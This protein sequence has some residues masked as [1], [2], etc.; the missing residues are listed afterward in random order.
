MDT[1]ATPVNIPADEPNMAEDESLQKGHFGV[2][3]KYFIEAAGLLTIWSLLVINEGAIRFANLT[4][5]SDLTGGRPAKA[6][7]FVAA[8]MEITFGLIGLAIGASAL[9]L[10]WFNANAVYGA[11]GLQTIMGIYVFLMYV[12]L[13]PIYKSIDQGKIGVM[14]VHV[15]LSLSENRALI[16]M[17]L[18]T[19]FN[20]CLALQG[21]QFV[22]FARLAVGGTGKNVLMQKTGNFMRA[23][24][25]NANLALSG[26]WT[27]VT[28]AVINAQVGDGKLEGPFVSPPNV[29]RLPGLTI[30]TGLLVMLWGFAGIGFAAG[31]MKA[32]A[33]Y[34]YGSFI[35]Y[36]FSYLNYT[37]VQFGLIDA[38]ASFAGPISMHGGLV[39]MVTMLGPYF[40]HQANK[41]IHGE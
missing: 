29:G 25:W 24:F 18:L 6:A 10:K 7:L 11:M 31:K 32:P 4:P 35:V 41:E 15:G 27:I 1:E 2:N 5:L 13:V 3:S 30:F 23:I 26:L 9:V 12:F 14:P 17:G 28:G 39:F 40:V 34:Y 20:W 21:G 37:I 38:P 8:L 36:L 19:S 16:T 33:G 22:F